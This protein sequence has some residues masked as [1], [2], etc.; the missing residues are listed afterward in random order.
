MMKVRKVGFP[1]VEGALRPASEV[2]GLLFGSGECLILN[3]G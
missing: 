3:L 1:L 2:F